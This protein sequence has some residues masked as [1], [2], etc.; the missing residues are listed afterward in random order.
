MSM[1]VMSRKARAKESLTKKNSLL[2]TFALNYTNT[3]KNLMGRTSSRAKVLPPLLRASKQRRVDCCKGATEVVVA[4]TCIPSSK[5]IEKVPLHQISNQAR[6]NKIKRYECA[7]GTYRKLNTQDGSLWQLSPEAHASTLTER[8][9]AMA[10]Q[11]ERGCTY[12]Y[13]LTVV[14]D[15]GNKFLLNGNKNL[16]LQFKVGNTYIFDISDSTNAGHPF[17]FVTASGGNT[18]YEKI[19]KIGTEGQKNAKLIFKPEKKGKAWM[20]CQT[21]GTAMGEYYNTAQGITVE[22]SDENLIKEKLCKNKSARTTIK[23]N[24]K[25]SCPSKNPLLFTTK[26]IRENTVASDASDRIRRMKAKA[27]YCD[28]NRQ[29]FNNKKCTPA[30]ATGV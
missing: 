9:A 25:L 24:R 26:D 11:K 12:N 7:D 28:R 30:G 20:H 5:G 6:L 17:T 22:D 27:L 1:V 15:G 16:F 10:L 4:K 8:L 2:G 14:V 18:L 21:H 23:R 19:D 3:G 13:K 29:P